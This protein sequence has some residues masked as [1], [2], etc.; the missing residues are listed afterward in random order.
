MS[1]FFIPALTPRSNH[2]HQ[3]VCYADCCSGIPATLHETNFAAVNA[4][5]S[6]L[7]AQ[8]RVHL[9]SGRR[10][11]GLV[12]D[13]DELRQQWHHWFEHEMAWLDR[14]SILLYHTTG[15]H[16]TYDP[17]SEMIFREVLGAPAEKWTR[18]V[19]RD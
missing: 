2:G 19:R 14:E 9:L 18:Q 11:Q 10:D 8:T 3:F 16:T 13:S 15:N 1:E 17:A 4:V 5:V 12:A 6:H 7:A